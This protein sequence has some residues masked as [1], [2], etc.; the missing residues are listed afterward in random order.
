LLSVFVTILR[1]GEQT[2]SEN[3]RKKASYKASIQESKQTPGESLELW[4]ESI[5]NLKHQMGDAPGQKA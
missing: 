2:W 3:Y 1:S 4:L 5:G